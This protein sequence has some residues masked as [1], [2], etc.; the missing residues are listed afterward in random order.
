MSEKKVLKTLEGVR[1]LVRERSTD[2]VFKRVYIPKADGRWRPLG[3]PNLVWRVYLHMLSNLVVFSR[4]D[5][6]GQHAY[7][8]GRGVH[9]AW[10]DI[11]MRVD[12]VP[13]IY[14]FDLTSFFD[15]V[16]LEWLRRVSVRDLGWPAEV[17]S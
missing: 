15:R 3:V 14:E 11:L 12:A 2:I 5:H 16:N 4:G 1:T 10:R 17:A 6:G 8:P 7:V 13:N 9:T